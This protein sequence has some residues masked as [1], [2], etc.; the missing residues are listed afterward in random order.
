MVID[1]NLSE[2]VLEEL[3]YANEPQSGEALAEKLNVSRNA[4]WKAVEALRQHG[5]E[6]DAATNKGYVLSEN[7]TKLCGYLIERK[8]KFSSD[9]IFSDET[10]STNAV[11]KRLAEDGAKEGTVAVSLSQT[12]GRGRLGRS[13]YSPPSGIYLSLLLRPKFSLQQSLMLTVAAAV[14]VCNA[15]E[16]NS[17][18]ECQIKW[19]N[20]VYINGKKVCGILTEGAI[21]AETGS[22]KYAVVGVGINLTAPKGGFPKDI[23]DR[24][25]TVFKTD[26]IRAEIAASV[27]AD[28]LNGFFEYYREIDKKQFMCEYRKRSYLD[29]KTVTVEQD[30]KVVTAL[31]LGID[32][33]G[34][35]IVKKGE[36]TELL[37]AGDVTIGAS[38]A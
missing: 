12:A 9:V 30:G 37:T 15:I 1:M 35:L 32:E 7:N 19:V 29:G 34:G 5:Y 31:V 36:K 4:V 27:S 3:A 14:A 2:K 33:N 11:I 10:D 20:D 21:E 8:L 22:L 25:D 16:K 23:A 26:E 6:I 13:F 18:F 17:G 24:A 28:A 38:Y